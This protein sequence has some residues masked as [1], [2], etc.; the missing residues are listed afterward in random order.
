MNI[1]D[2]IVVGG[3]LAGSAVSY[4]LAKAGFSVL[5]LEQSDNPQ[6]ATRYSYGGIAYWAGTTDL[7]RQ[8][9]QEGIEIHRSL[10][11]E[12]DAETQFR[13]LNLL[14][15]VALDRDP[16]QVAAAYA[17]C[18][19]VPQILDPVE[20]QAIEPLLRADQIAAALRFS[21]GHVSPEATVNAYRQ[22]FLR[23]GGTL[24]IAQVT[25]LLRRGDRIQGVATAV[26]N[27]EAGNVAISAG[28][29]SRKLL[30][31]AN[32]PVR[33]YFT[34]A[35]MIEMPPIELRLQAI[36]M[37]AE[38]QRFVMEAQAGSKDQDALWDEAGHEVFPAVLDA[39]A[40]QFQNSMVR[41]GQ[42]SRTYTDPY[43]CSDAV[44][45][46]AAMRD[47]VGQILP[48]LKDLPG[49]W[50]TCLV[51]FSGDGLPLIGSLP[52]AEGIHIFSGF[53][54]PFSILPPLARR[55]AHHVAGTA[56]GLIAQLSPSR[57]TVSPS[58]R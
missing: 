32:L 3:G 17:N 39:G 36:V 21:H 27:F 13:E 55:F 48:A 10:S 49:Q 42:I 1:Y 56:D 41:I 53:S 16:E 23:I 54:N 25:G 8:L 33:V 11:A 31:S 58:T 14:L 29:M 9:C 6:N 18:T 50:H 46:E 45:S 40:I 35:E 4:E 5:L 20:A 15:T 47:A 30:R 26:G 7:T 43:K 52:H 57:L 12:L 2:W 37:P 51:A 34:Q 28:G 44:L 24:Q 22:A 19:A 38:L